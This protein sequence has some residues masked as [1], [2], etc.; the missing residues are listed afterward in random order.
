MKLHEPFSLNLARTD[1]T[2]SLIPLGRDVRDAVER[3]LSK[4]KERFFRNTISRI[5]PMNLV[6]QRVSP[7]YALGVRKCWTGGTPILPRRFM[8][9]GSCK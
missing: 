5:A 2:P 6:G 9:R 8:G 7:V 4:F 3:V 1:S